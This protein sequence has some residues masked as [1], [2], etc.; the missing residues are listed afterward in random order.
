MMRPVAHQHLRQQLLL[1]LLV[2]LAGLLAACTDTA[3]NDPP[4]P[5]QDNPADAATEPPGPTADKAPNRDDR[6][7][8]DDPDGS[9]GEDRTERNL[10][11]LAPRT[12][13]PLTEPVRDRSVDCDPDRLAFFQDDCQPAA[14][15][16]LSELVAGGPGPDDIPSI[17]DPRFES[18]ADAGAW[19]DDRSPV[20]MLELDGITRLYPLEILVRHEIVNDEI[21]GGPVAVT[22]CPLCNSALAFE[23]TMDGPD[24]PE[25][26]EFGTSGRL[27][28]SNLVM[29]DREHL[30]LWSQFTGQAIVGERF[31]G[32]A[33][34]RIPTSLLG[35][36]SAAEL[37]PDA[38]V[39]SRD[40]GLDVDYELTPYVSFDREDTRPAFLRNDPDDRLPPMTRVVGIGRGSTS[41]AVVLGHLAVEEVVELELDGDPVTVWWTPGQA[42]V[43]GSRRVEDGRELGQAVVYVAQHDGDPLTFE[44]T[45]GGRFADHQTGST[46]DLRGRAVDGPLLGAELE[47]VPR[48]DVLWFAWAVYRPLT[49]VVGAP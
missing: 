11:E 35:F 37:A 21:A 27:W 2:A 22:Y 13:G 7:D 32:D 23:R 14:M 42:S 10:R 28:R 38:E 9:D 47:P 45:G 20:V 34:P 29:Y 41:V 17:D 19:L 24:G 36:A 26:L 18:V 25:I 44:P 31:L 1:L 3:S 43:L 6:P 33:L 46:W 30:G 8:R 5:T 16:E 48:D 4:D 39:L 15:I 40:T 12:T 49:T